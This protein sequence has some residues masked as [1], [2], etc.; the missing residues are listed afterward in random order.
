MFEELRD[1]SGG[2]TVTTHPPRDPI[3][4]SA[5]CFLD[6]S[7]ADQSLHETVTC[8]NWRPTV[9]DPVPRTRCHQEQSIQGCARLSAVLASNQSEGANFSAAVARGQRQCRDRPSPCV[10]EPTVTRAK[11]FAFVHRYTTRDCKRPQLPALLLRWHG[12]RPL[13]LHGAAGL[14]SSGRSRGKLLQATQP[15]RSDG[16]LT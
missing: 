2:G 14:Y 15:S 6:P 16:G 10:S 13:R 3:R 11:R 8:I 1:H 5:E 9:S 12:S 4:T 7:V